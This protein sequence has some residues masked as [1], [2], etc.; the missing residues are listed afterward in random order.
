LEAL[1]FK[2]PHSSKP[3][4]AQNIPLDSI[5][6]PPP[7]TSSGAVPP[8]YPQDVA[9]Q[10]SPE[11]HALFEEAERCPLPKD[12]SFSSVD[13]GMPTPMKK[14]KRFYSRRELQEQY[15]FTPTEDGASAPADCQW[16]RQPHL[17]SYRSGP[18]LIM[19]QSSSEDESPES[20]PKRHVSFQDEDKKQQQPPSV[21]GGILKPPQW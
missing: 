4:V 3:R 19:T 15:G 21:Q 11:T 12:D 7:S 20:Q 1:R 14:I 10:F 13:D 17:S 18:H 6:T 16:M 9:H 2:F 8:D 5:L